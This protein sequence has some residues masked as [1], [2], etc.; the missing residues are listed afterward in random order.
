MECANC[1]V[2]HGLGGGARVF[3]LGDQHL[4]AMVGAG[5]GGGSVCMPTLRAADANENDLFEFLV[6]LDGADRA[7]N[8]LEEGSVVFVQSFSMLKDLGTTTQYWEAIIRLRNRII[9]HFGLDRLGKP[10]VE[11]VPA[12]V[13]VRVQSEPEAQLFSSYL[14]TA[15]ALKT[16]NLMPVL[17]GP[18]WTFFSLDFL[19]NKGE[20]VSAGTVPEETGGLTTAK[21]ESSANLTTLAIDLNENTGAYKTACSGAKKVLQ[22]IDDYFKKKATSLSQ[23]GGEMAAREGGSKTNSQGEDPW[24]LF[25]SLT[26]RELNSSIQVGCWLF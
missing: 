4:P 13:P 20:G 18:I 3:L 8:R 26:R 5:T 7:W 22:E 2:R 25:L 21:T 16:Q 15:T 14:E 24:I 12:V 11:L 17:L 9:E 23:G 6:A 10:K 1:A 19:A